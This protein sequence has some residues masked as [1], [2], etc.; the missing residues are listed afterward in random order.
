L[1]LSLRI[2]AVVGRRAFGIGGASAAEGTTSSSTRLPVDSIYAGNQP[3]TVKSTVRL[4]ALD[5]L[6]GPVETPLPK[7]RL[8]ELTLDYDAAGPRISPT[9][10]NRSLRVLDLQPPANFLR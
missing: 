1:R 8:R 4:H 6:C 3:D 9:F 7:S 5:K 10:R 2:N